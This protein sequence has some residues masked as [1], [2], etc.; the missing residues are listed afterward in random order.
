[1]KTTQ[2]TIRDRFLWIESLHFLLA[3]K[4]ITLHDFWLLSGNYV[5]LKVLPSVE[6]DLPANVKEDLR[7]QRILARPNFRGVVANKPV[8][9]LRSKGIFMD[10]T[11]RFELDLK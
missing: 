7:I 10:T 11:E 4:I 2:T 1:M 3:S 8:V 5:T 6:E 9:V